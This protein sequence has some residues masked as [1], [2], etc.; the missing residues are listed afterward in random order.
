MT[1]KNSSA[2][3]PLPEIIKEKSRQRLKAQAERKES[4]FFGLG[5][6]GTVGWS[7]AIPAVVGVMVGRWLDTLHEGKI[8]WTMTLFFTGLGLGL[9]IA[10]QWLNREGRSK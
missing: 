7:I 1:T 10:W 4:F 8:S 6:F 2:K 9:I 5:M 3:E